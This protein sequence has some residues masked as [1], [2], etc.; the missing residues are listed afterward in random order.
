[1]DS[2]KTYEEYVLAKLDKL[3]ADDHRK[4]DT[5]FSLEHIIYSLQTVFH[6]VVGSDNKL[7]INFDFEALEADPDLKA[8]LLNIFGVLQK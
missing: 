4:D 2:I 5:I 6:I 7:S 1:M 8:M 3:E